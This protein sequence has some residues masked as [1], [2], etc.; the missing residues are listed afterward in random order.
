MEDD[1]GQVAADDRPKT[2][3]FLADGGQRTPTTPGSPV[4]RERGV[5]RSGTTL[6]ATGKTALA[7][8]PTPVVLRPA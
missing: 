8:L 1:D 6:P 3:G 7:G 5:R 4:E 2:A